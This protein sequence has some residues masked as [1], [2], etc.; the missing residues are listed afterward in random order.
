MEESEI[1]WKC[2]KRR[3]AVRTP[4]TAELMPSLAERPLVQ[5]ESEQIWRLEEK[6]EVSKRRF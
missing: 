1:W 2:Q 4:F 5:T 6:P 3:K